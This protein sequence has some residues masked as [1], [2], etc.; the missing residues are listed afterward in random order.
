MPVN[1]LGFVDVDAGMLFPLSCES[2]HTGRC[3][4]SLWLFLRPC[5]YFLRPCFFL[6]L[7]FRNC[8]VFVF[9]C[10]VSGGESHKEIC[11][12]LWITK[13]K[14]SELKQDTITISISG[15]I[16]CRNK[17]NQTQRFVSVTHISFWIL[18]SL[19]PSLTP[20]TFTLDHAW[21]WNKHYWK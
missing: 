17:M 14:I 15:V 2:K 5:N 16:F 20:D 1:Q 9:G 13:K 21:W 3:E 19:Y 11:L 4:R 18:S 7:L 6:S 12:N 10:H 8:Q